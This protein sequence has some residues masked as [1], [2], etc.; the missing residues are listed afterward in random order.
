[1]K[2]TVVVLAGPTKLELREYELSDPEPGCILTEVVQANVCGSELHIWTGQHPSVRYGS[3]IGHEMVLRV[4]K[5]GP[6]VTTDFA[7]QPLKEGD[8]IVATYFQVCRRCPACQAG[9]W[10]LCTNA[11]QYW[12]LPADVPPHF[13][14][15]FATHY[16]IHPDQYVY[17]VPDSVPDGPA[18]S[19]N[20]ALSQ[21][22]FGVDQAGVKAGEVVVVQGAGGL[23]LCGI[24]ASRVRGAHVI[25]VDSVPLRLQQAREFG[26]DDVIDLREYPAFADRQARVLSLTGQV[27]PDVVLDVTGVA[28]TFEDGWQLLRPGGRLVE[29]G[30]ISPGKKTEVDIGLMTRR[31]VQILAVLRYYPWYLRQAIEFLDRY[32]ERFPFHGLLDAEYPLT[33]VEQALRDS[34]DRKVTRASLV[35]EQR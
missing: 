4:A 19:A 23:G 33:D 13:H 34:T 31:G 15:S 14:A 18:A 9:Q 6:G 32:G 24:A 30:T 1:M 20:C 26:A 21:M 8:R 5:L 27:G 16:Y 2:G 25:A 28:S 22:L 3:V 35:V 11:F 12:S 29:I 17:K 10:N 7:G